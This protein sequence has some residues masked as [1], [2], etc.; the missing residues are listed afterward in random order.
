MRGTFVQEQILESVAMV[1][2][3]VLGL[4]AIALGIVPEG[5]SGS[6]VGSFITAKSVAYSISGLSIAEQGSVTRYLHGDYDIEIGI[7]R[8]SSGPFNSYYVTV[9]YDNDKPKKPINKIIFAGDLKLT[10]DPVKFVNV[11]YLSFVKDFGEPVEIK[12]VSESHFETKQCDE[13][14]P[15]RIKEYI[16]SNSKDKEEEKWVKTIINVESIGFKHC[17]SI[18][19]VGAIG[20]MQLMPATAD[21]LGVGDPYDAEQNIQG[22]IKY[23]RILQDRYKD[24]DD[25]EILAIANYNCGKILTLVRE[26]CEAQN[27]Y[28]NCYE[29]EVK[30]FLEHDHCQGQFGQETYNHIIKVQNCVAY[31]EANPDCYN[32][33]G[34][35]GC[36]RSNTCK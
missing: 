2:I 12:S 36:P 15:Q 29:N 33:P 17:V 22:G 11:S 3:V 4:V 25:K 16:Q 26:N 5:F 6:D 23:F 9:A 28:Q 31:Y 14:S 19:G 13:P 27:I 30:P 10:N 7:E 18:S 32:A 35:Y 8:D 24:Y 34:N 20:L 21:Y 1:I